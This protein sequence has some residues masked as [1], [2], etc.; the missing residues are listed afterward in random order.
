MYA[1]LEPG[2]RNKS[3]VEVLGGVLKCATPREEEEEEEEETLD[4]QEKYKRERN[5]VYS[6]RVY[7]IYSMEMRED[8]RFTD[9]FWN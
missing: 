6:L 7:Y 4:P 3:N 8:T 1:G 2:F 5:I 9:I